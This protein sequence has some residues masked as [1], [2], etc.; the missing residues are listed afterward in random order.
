MKDTLIALGRVIL[1]HIKGAAYD[2]RYIILAMGV[3]YFVMAVILTFAIFAA[4]T[5]HLAVM[6]MFISGITAIVGAIHV[7][8]YHMSKAW[9]VYGFRNRL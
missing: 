5:V 7:E 3:L 4:P 8:V 9:S 2:G 1:A 6:T